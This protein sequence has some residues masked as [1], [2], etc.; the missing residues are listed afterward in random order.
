M[1]NYQ[2]LKKKISIVGLLTKKNKI[3]K[4][5]LYLFLTVSLIFSSCKK[6][7]DE[8]TVINGCT[9]S[10]A[11]NYN[12]NATNDDAS[13]MYDVSGVWE[14]T[15]AVLNGV[16]QLAG[17]TDLYYIWDNGQ[18][19][20]ETYD[21]S[22]TMMGYSIGTGTLVA[23]NPNVLT[24]SGEVYMDPNNPSVG[25]PASLTVNI[26]FIT[27]NNNMTWRYVNYP[28]AA[29]TYVKT[30]VRSSTYSLSDWK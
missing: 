30:L 4:K 23:G 1:I 21:A 20:T 5:I 12:A 16:D 9:D 28:T 7:E 22:G 11:T 10:Q 19:G 13:C 24:W 26:D 8:P 3:M 25:V 15:S 29:D 2:Y 14:T 6:E 17:K 18:L 27:N